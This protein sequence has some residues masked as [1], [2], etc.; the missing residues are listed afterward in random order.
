MLLPTHF[1]IHFYTIDLHWIIKDFSFFFYLKS[2]LIVLNVIKILNKY[3]FNITINMIYYIGT[4]TMA[5]K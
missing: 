4:T 1:A 5:Y 3:N 2:H